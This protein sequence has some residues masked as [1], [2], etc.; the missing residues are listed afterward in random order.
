M[1]QH[2][3]H[4][5]RSTA[6]SCCLPSILFT[7]GNL[8]TQEDDYTAQ[9]LVLFTSIDY[10]CSLSLTSSLLM[11]SSPK[12]NKKGLLISFCS[13]LVHLQTRTQI[14]SSLEVMWAEDSWYK[15]SPNMRKSHIY[16]HNSPVFITHPS[17][18]K[19]VPRHRPYKHTHTFPKVNPD[20]YYLQHAHC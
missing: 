4:D 13:Q 9:K 3:G 20:L 2:G 19:T 11:P 8:T 14:S 6:S 16:T 18:V 15:L 7:W 1:S 17:D 5:H 10:R 12:N